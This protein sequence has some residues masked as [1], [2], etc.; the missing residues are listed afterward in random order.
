MTIKM[1]EHV[2]VTQETIDLMIQNQSARW[3]YWPDSTGLTCTYANHDS[4]VR[5]AGESLL[6]TVAGSPFRESTPVPHIF[7]LSVYDSEAHLLYFR[8]PT[9]TI[10]SV[11]SPS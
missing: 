6:R 10:F 5:V 11:S 9:V 4:R 2:I 7:K 3:W 1:C 8:I